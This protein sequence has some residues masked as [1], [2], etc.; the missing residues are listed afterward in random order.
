MF[1][2]IPF[3]RR[4]VLAQRVTIS[5][6]LPRFVLDAL[7]YRVQVANEEA[8]PE[9][10]VLLNDVIEWYLISPLTL[11]E[12]PHIDAAVPG[13]TGALANWLLRTGTSRRSSLAP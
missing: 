5:V 12:V 10:Q 3:Q 13:F 7:Q 9:E 11:K 4:E 1:R 8:A 2:V 6:E